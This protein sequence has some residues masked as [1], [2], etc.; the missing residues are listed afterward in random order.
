MQPP[1]LKG[2]DVFGDG[3]LFTQPVRISVRDAEKLHSHDFY[4]IFFLI[5][6]EMLHTVGGMCQHIKKG[7]AVFIRPQDAHSFD[8]YRG[9][10]CAFI[11]VAFSESVL[12]EL[13]SFYGCSHIRHLWENPKMPCVD[14][15]DTEDKAWDSLLYQANA[16]MAVEENEAVRRV[17]IKNLIAELYSHFTQRLL[18]KEAQPDVPDWLQ[19]LCER[20]SYPDQLALGVQAIHSL[21]YYSYEYVSRCFQ[22]YFHVTPTQYILNLRLSYAALL[23]SQT[24]RSVLDIALDTGFTSCSYFSRAFTAKY[25]LP[26]ARYRRCN[27]RFT[28]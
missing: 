7:E 11:N 4:E 6:G 26:P 22:R 27:G 2:S 28:V 10:D 19:I 17:R 1:I 18:Q 15:Y 21:S 8:T 12:R 20:L 14:I 23:L 3:D 24:R 13:E 16:C 25:G 5:H 9:M